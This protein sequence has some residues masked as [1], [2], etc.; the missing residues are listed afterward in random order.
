MYKYCFIFWHGFGFTGEWF[1]ADPED[2]INQALQT[3]AGPNVSDAFT[4]NGLPGPFYNC[5]SNGIYRLTL[6]L[7][8]FIS[9]V[10]FNSQYS[11]IFQTDFKIVVFSGKKI[12]YIFSNYETTKPLSTLVYY[13]VLCVIAFHI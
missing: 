2:V 10:Q 11:I 1:N 5:S 4:I 9:F 13:F 3:G 6:L 7:L 8:F 12:K